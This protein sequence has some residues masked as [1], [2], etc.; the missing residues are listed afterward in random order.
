MRR[1]AGRR[2]ARPPSARGKRRTQSESLFVNKAS[3]ERRQARPHC[4]QAWTHEIKSFDEV[5]SL[6][7]T[8][9]DYADR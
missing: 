2:L 9:A 1:Q 8:A 5:R 6:H 4:A 7:M 3:K